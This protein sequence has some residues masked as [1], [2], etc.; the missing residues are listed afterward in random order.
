M[1]KLEWLRREFSYGYDSGDVLSLFPRAR[2]REEEQR[3]G[4]SYRNVFMR[5][6][7]PNIQPD[8]TV[9]ELGP[10]AGSWSRAILKY[11]PKGKLMTVDFQDVAPWLHPE[12]YGGRLVCS[13][14]PDNSFSCIQ[15]GT[16]DFFW[17][18]GVL[19]HNNT[20]HIAEILR[21]ALPKMKRGA[22]AAHQYAEWD[23]LKAFGWEK[24]TIPTEFK[25]KPDEE[26]WWPRNNRATMVGLAE[27]A[28]WKVVEADMGLIKR[29]G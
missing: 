28:G 11:V 1:P 27:S 26:I 7:R 17:S 21:N 3:C 8:S 6:A 2:R 24:G 10:G 5:A 13:R 16:V 29:D 23:K 25:D 22:M 15:N 18:F 12:Q 20:T 9:M 19:C 14:V 4:A